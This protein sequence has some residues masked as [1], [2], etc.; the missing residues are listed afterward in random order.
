MDELKYYLKIEDFNKSI[1]VMSNN[2]EDTTND[3]Y[4]MSKELETIKI[5]M[6]QLIT[7]TATLRQQIEN[8][9]KKRIEFIGANKFS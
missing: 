1:D 2:F 9:S 5:E 3:I 8:A 4:L 7:E 6:K